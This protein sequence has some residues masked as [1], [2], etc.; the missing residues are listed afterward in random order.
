MPS[1]GSFPLLLPHS[2]WKRLH[3]TPPL[4]KCGVVCAASVLFLA[5]NIMLEARGL[6]Q[7][8]SSTSRR[9]VRIDTSVIYQRLMQRFGLSTRIWRLRTRIRS[10]SRA[11]IRLWTALMRILKAVPTFTFSSIRR[12][13]KRFLG[14]FCYVLMTLL[15]WP[16]NF[17]WIC[18]RSWSRVDL[19]KLGSM[20]CMKSWLRCGVGLSIASRFFLVAL[21]MDFK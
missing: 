1:P 13:S 19:I 18:S 12:S 11:C 14:S 17:C 16:M 10:S 6:A 9:F 2:A 8:M 5:A 15:A 21:L 7:A 3:A 20:T 4:E